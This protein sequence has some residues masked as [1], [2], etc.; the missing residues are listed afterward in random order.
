MADHQDIKLICIDCE[1]E[2]LFTVGEQLFYMSKDLTAPKRCKNCRDRRKRA[3]MLKQQDIDAQELDRLS[4][5][6]QETAKSDIPCDKTDTLY[7]IGNGF[8]L[9]HDVPSSYKCF[10][11]SIGKRT[12]LR[13]ALDN[14]LKVKEWWADFEEALA[15]LDVGKMRNDITADMWLDLFEVYSP[16]VKASDFFMAAETIMGPANTITQDLPRRFRMWVESLKVPTAERPL[17]DLIVNGKVLCFNYT[18]FIEDL[19]GVAHKNVC[20]IHGCR[21]KQKSHPKEDLVLGHRPVWEYD[22]ELPSKVIPHLHTGKNGEL[23]EAVYDM[24]TNYLNWYDDATTKDCTSIIRVHQ[25]FFTSLDDIRK[26]V[27]IGHSMAP[28]DWDYF[29]EIHRHCAEVDWYV[30]Y[31]SANDL[32]NCEKLMTK[33]DIAQSKVHIFKP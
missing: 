20:Y 27:I 18:E 14:Y 12:Q 15:H 23:L 24:T 7:I 25:N 28:V 13:Y 11:D 22:G 19:Y 3:A 33:M 8:D 5:K 32:R 6:F 17:K 29:M 30:G 16:D 10:R 4:R 31:Y 9:M 2:F 26:V 1:K 21:K